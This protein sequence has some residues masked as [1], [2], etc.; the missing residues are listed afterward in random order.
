MEKD[1]FYLVK[2]YHKTSFIGNWN[3]AN[4][5]IYLLENILRLSENENLKLKTVKLRTKKTE[6]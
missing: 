6:C 5:C 3:E 4:E 1:S 2:K